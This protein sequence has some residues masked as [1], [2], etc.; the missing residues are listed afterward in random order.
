MRDPGLDIVRPSP[1]R[2]L[3]VRFGERS[4]RGAILRESSR[5][6]GFDFTFRC[7]Y[8]GN[9][10]LVRSLPKGRRSP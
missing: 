4:I 2:H 9:P 8:G 3:W 10:D 5:I 7:R 6:P 1:E